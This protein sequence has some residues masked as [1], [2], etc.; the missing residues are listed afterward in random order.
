L[1]WN[2]LHV[3]VKLGMFG[4]LTPLLQLGIQHHQCQ[5]TKVSHLPYGDRTVITWFFVKDH[6]VV[7]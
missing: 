1:Y 7:I 3:A 5:R 2:S 6:W 4:S